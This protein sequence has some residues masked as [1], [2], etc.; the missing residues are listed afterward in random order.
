MT[1]NLE[2][3]NL[4]KQK[5]ALNSSEIF[6]IEYLDKRYWIKKARETKS[7]LT[8]KFYYS[9]FGFDILLP[10]K[11]KTAQQSI[12]HETNKIK[13]FQSLGLSMPNIVFQDENN[14]ALEDCGKT[15]N[16]Y[17]RK[18]DITKDKMYYFINKV[19]DELSKIHNFNEYHGG[20]QCRNFT[21]RDG[22]ISIIDLEDSFSDDIDIKTLQFRDFVLFLLSLTKTR[23]SFELDYQIIIN[24]YISLTNNNDFTD[25][26]NKL[27]NKISFLINL[28]EVKFINNILGKDLKS[29][30][31]LFKI[32][33]TLDISYKK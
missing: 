28:S 11:Y 24:Q 15:V 29:F 14:F 10:V 9:I 3:E 4:I 26:L 23:A 8:H 21:Y 7:S 20:A 17:I 12:E 22:N 27:A 33:K 25:R 1:N 2:L 16:S 19:I 5:I 32:L 6:S 13:R 31:R 30:F 18:R